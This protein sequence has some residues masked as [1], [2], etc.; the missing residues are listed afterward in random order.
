MYWLYVACTV[1]SSIECHCHAH[2]FNICGVW[3]RQCDCT[4]ECSQFHIWLMA[5][6]V[7]GVGPRFSL[8]MKPDQLALWLL[9]EYGEAYEKDIGKLKGR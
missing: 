8:D 4:C 6:L 5:P 3:W 7:G 2:C 9:Q 1:S